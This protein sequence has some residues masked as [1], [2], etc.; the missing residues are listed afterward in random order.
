[1]VSSAY[2]LAM[3][4]DFSLKQ[5]D[6]AMSLVRLYLHMGNLHQATNELKHIF[7]TKTEDRIMMNH[8]R[9]LTCDLP[10][11]GLEMFGLNFIT[12]PQDISSVNFNDENHAKL[13]IVMVSRLATVCLAV[14]VIYIY[15]YM[16]IL[17]VYI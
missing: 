1:M 4:R 3:G 2:W 7:S 8:F 16:Y 13:C 12:Y 6:C 10:M 5:V 17:C 11:Y 14:C 9:L 15:M